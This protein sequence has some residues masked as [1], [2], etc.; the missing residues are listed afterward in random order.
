[1]ISCLITFSH[2]PQRPRVDTPPTTTASDPAFGQ[3]SD[4]R[5]SMPK[6]THVLVAGERVPGS[7]V[8][9]ASAVGRITPIGLAGCETTDD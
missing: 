6:E 4:T 2:T 1:M 7:S 9:P 8:Q 5:Q 3:T